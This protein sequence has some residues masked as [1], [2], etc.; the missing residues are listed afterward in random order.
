VDGQTIDLNKIYN[1]ATTS[2]YVFECGDNVTAFNNKPIL[3]NHD[4]LICGAIMIEYLQTLN[5][6]TGDPPLRFINLEN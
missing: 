4:S 3:C 1:V 2:F 6:I 5:S